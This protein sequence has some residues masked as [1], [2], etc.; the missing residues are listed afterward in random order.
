M[1][2]AVCTSRFS[3]VVSM[4]FLHDGPRSVIARHPSPHCTAGNGLTRVAMLQPPQ[5]ADL[6]STEGV[7]VSKR[8][9]PFEIYDFVSATNVCPCPHSKVDS[10][11]DGLQRATSGMGDR[12]L[13]GDHPSSF[14]RT[15]HV[16]CVVLVFPAVSMRMA[17]QVFYQYCILIG[18]SR[19]RPVR[20]SD[21]TLQM[22]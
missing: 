17:V 13:P 18:L 20:T 5:H 9:D 3:I 15:S 16:T 6:F 19:S 21:H 7:S 14:D 11:D 1:S 8:T 2:E 10:A 22:R 4:S 12:F